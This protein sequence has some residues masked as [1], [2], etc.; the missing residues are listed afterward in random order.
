MEARPQDSKEERGAGEEGAEGERNMSRT[1]LWQKSV[2][3]I[4]TFVWRANK[5]SDNVT[6]AVAPM[7][8]ST[9]SAL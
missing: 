4:H 3:V 5:V 2:S 1:P 8:H 6:S 7:A 9:S